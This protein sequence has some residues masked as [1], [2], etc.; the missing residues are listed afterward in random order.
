MGR[1]TRLISA[2]QVAHLEVKVPEAPRATV[3]PSGNS[4]NSSSIFLGSRGNLT[5]SPATRLLALTGP[6]EECLPAISSYH[7]YFW[8]TQSLPRALLRL[9]LQQ[10]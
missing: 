2:R 8:F 6:L 5:G 9:L 4:Q 10:V 3:L 7:S 1:S